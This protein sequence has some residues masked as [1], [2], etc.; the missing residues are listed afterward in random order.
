MTDF[1]LI[2][3]GLGFGLLLAVLVGPIVITLIQSCFQGGK[4][5]GF[6]VTAG[7]W[8][9]D[10][11]ILTASYYG[12][13]SLSQRLGGFSL[14]SWLQ[15]LGGAIFLLVGGYIA[16]RRYE[17][18]RQKIHIST[19]TDHGKYFA[20]GFIV[21]TIN[22]FTFAFWLTVCSSQILGRGLNER[23]AWVYLLSIFFT[24]VLTDSM[25]VLLSDW[26]RTKIPF[27]ILTIVQR[28]AGLALAIV[29]LYLLLFYQ[30]ADI[31]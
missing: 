24:I 8:V 23:Q 18:F 3:E 17:D 20:K 27:K 22:P 13:V 15:Y 19:I 5:A 16:I 1:Q 21:N 4:V 29:G 6:E 12:M 14:E 9:S 30:S 31:H 10:I 2:L 11:I 25:K 7:I 26:L 28:I